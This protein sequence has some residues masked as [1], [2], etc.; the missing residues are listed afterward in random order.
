MKS[1]S[2]YYDEYVLL[3]EKRSY[4]PLVRLARRAIKDGH[5]WFKIPLTVAAYFLKRRDALEIAEDAVAHFPNNGYL[6]RWYARILEDHEHSEDALK[7]YKRAAEL[8]GWW[9]SFPTYFSAF[10]RLKGGDVIEFEG[11]LHDVRELLASLIDRMSEVPEQHLTLAVNALNQLCQE[12]G[13]HVTQHRL[14]KHAF[15][16]V[17][18]AFNERLVASTAHRLGYTQL[19][20]A[21]YTALL[22]RDDGNLRFLKE[23]E[24]FLHD[25]GRH[26]QALARVQARYEDAPSVEAATAYIFFASKG[27]DAQGIQPLVDE[28]MERFG[29]HVEVMAASMFVLS[30]LGNS[31]LAMQIGRKLLKRKNIKPFTLTRLMTTFARAKHMSLYE[32]ARQRFE[33]QQ[34]E[35][36]PWM[37]NWLIWPA[38]A[39]LDLEEAF[40]YAQKKS[41][42]YPHMAFT[43]MYCY[44]LAM[45]LGLQER[46]AFYRARVF[47]PNQ[48]G[49]AYDSNRAEVLFLEEDE[50]G[51]NALVNRMD[52]DPLMTSQFIEL[53]RMWLGMLRGVYPSLESLLAMR[54]IP[55]SGD[56]YVH[57]V[58]LVA[59]HEGRMDVAED[60]YARRAI[61]SDIG[62]RSSLDLLM[63][64]KFSSAYTQQRTGS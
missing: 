60:V 53:F 26:A 6:L 19:A 8:G 43:Q 33:S 36:E 55:T 20:E 30:S 52:A 38:H 12:H 28:V 4:E 7:Q 3:F 27:L 42:R 10:S 62:V 44:E 41:E 46:A 22:A 25:T 14:C 35:L 56:Y 63:F 15:E 45:M 13:F 34:P 57:T 2:D 59:L 5:D 18:N 17:P 39:K 11:S 58:G 9:E 37:F 31:E 23:Y 1:Y 51:L 29:K 61:S 40:S 47:D 54:G 49:L 64:Q 16:R 21:H 24:G 48:V 32:D 50:P